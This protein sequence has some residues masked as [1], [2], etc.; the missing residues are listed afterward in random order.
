MAECYAVQGLERTAGLL[1]VGR[2]YAR[3]LAR[4]YWEE[5]PLLDAQY[6]SR[7]CRDGGKLDLH[8]H[9]AGFP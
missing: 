3:A 2:P 9:R 1:G 6:R 5:Y 7:E 8:P 4:V